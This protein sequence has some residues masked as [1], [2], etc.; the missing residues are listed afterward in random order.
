VELPETGWLRRYRVR[1]HGHVGQDDLD[2]LRDGVA[3]DGIRY[4][5]IEAR[6]ERDQG[7][8]V[9]LSFAIREGKNREVRNVLGHLGLTVNRLIRVEFGP[10]GLGALAEGGIE[11]VET[12][13]LRTQLGARIAARAGCDF[14]GPAATLRSPDREERRQQRHT[15][16][17]ARRSPNDPDRD[18]DRRPAQKPLTGRDETPE[19]P[20]GRPRRGPAW[21]QAD[22]PLHRTY[23]GSRRDDLKIAAE[24]R[25]DK[26]TGVTTDRSGRRIVVE[27]FGATKEK[28]E[29]A[30]VPSQ[31]RRR[32]PPDRTS[33]PRPSRPRSVGERTERVQPGPRR[34]G[35]SDLRT[36]RSDRK[37]GHK[38]GHDAR[39]HGR[40]GARP[41]P[42]GRPPRKH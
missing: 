9:W 35:N 33:G 32:G 12:G 8:N 29:P 6:L 41:S 23:R 19:Q 10:F 13:N 37:A 18:R 5:P 14:A 38:S 34:E 25:P 11:E 16:R 15:L 4:G 2:R 28:P 7:A 31:G 39:P 20:S 42:S 36:A 27:R 3:I 24:G 17:G 22:A 30:R 40:R 21:R 1:A 26:R